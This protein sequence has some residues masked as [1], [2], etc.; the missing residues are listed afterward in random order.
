MQ[1]IGDKIKAWTGGAFELKVF[2]GDAI[3]PIAGQFDA[4][5]SGGLDALLESPANQRDRFGAIVQLFDEFPGGLS[6]PEH[7]AW[8][9]LG[10]Q[11]GLTLIRQLYKDTNVWI[12][13]NMS[14]TGPEME[15]WGNKKINTIADYKGLKMRT[16]GGWAEALKGFGTSIVSMAGSEIYG[17][18]QR[19]V[20]DAFEYGT[21]ASDTNM[22]WWEVAKYAAYP[23]IHS[24]G[25]G[26]PMLYVNKNKWNELTPAIQQMLTDLSRETAYRDFYNEIMN[27][28]AAVDF[29]K[30]KGMEVYMLPEPVQAAL[31]Q[32]TDKLND[33]YAAKDPFYKQVLDSQRALSAKFAAGN[34]M[35]ANFG[36]LRQMKL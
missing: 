27:D 18:M 8:Q 13:G 32:A 15:Y 34:G 12:V 1:E 23:G 14:A 2:P 20:I 11:D 30:S 33:D 3:V 31:V 7:L 29:Y 25:A 22:G 26:S 6:S 24:P 9:Y 35:V 16:G 28:G 36:K 19:G 5:T 21:P 4:M 17:A 10:K